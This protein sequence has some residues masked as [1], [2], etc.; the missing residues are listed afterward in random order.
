M[1]FKVVAYKGLGGN[2]TWTGCVALSNLDGLH[3]EW[4]ILVL[5]IH[6]MFKNWE[7]MH[8]RIYVSKP[9]NQL[10]SL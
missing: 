1:L 5:V 10:I 7:N 4:K 8:E 2:G 9:I 6:C 3:H